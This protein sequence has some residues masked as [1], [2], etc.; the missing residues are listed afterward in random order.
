[1]PNGGQLIKIM[2]GKLSSLKLQI[3]IYIKV[4]STGECT[5]ICSYTL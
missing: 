5:S 1:M 3:A 4:V 2:Q